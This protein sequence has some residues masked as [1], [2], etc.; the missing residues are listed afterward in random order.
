[1][2]LGQWG[3]ER[4]PRA[5][6]LLQVIS[7]HA[8]DGGGTA[9]VVGQVHRGPHALGEVADHMPLARVDH[10]L[11]AGAV[12]VEIR[13]VREH[14]GRGG[15]LQAPLAHGLRGAEL[16]L[17]APAV[18][19]QVHE[20]VRVVLAGGAGHREAGSHHQV[21]PVVHEFLQAQGGGPEQVGGQAHLHVG[22]AVH[23]PRYGFAVEAGGA[24]EP[25]IGRHHAE[26]GRLT[27]QSDRPRTTQQ[28]SVGVQ[29]RVR[30]RHGRVQRKTQTCKR[31]TGGNEVHADG[32]IGA[33]ARLKILGTDVHG[34]SG[35]QDQ[36]ERT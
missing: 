14:L 17:E 36:Y 15:Q 24:I 34:G 27:T 25:S 26:L 35:Q 4:A 5:P 12:D 32:R 1:M 2:P 29:V 9:R 28:C 21:L 18:G 16:A 22:K 30:Q 10:I 6:V 23:L 3:G 13:V 20:P 31:R 33:L 11:F 7:E 8:V 19:A